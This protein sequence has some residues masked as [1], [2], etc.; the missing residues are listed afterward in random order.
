MTPT[1]GYSLDLQLWAS[2]G[3]AAQYHLLASIRFGQIA[4][5]QAKHP[6]DLATL[7]ESR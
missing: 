5:P 6:Q 2:L 3:L 7:A 4:C 1:M